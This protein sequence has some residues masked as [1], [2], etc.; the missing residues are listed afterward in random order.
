MARHESLRTRFPAS[1]GAPWQQILPPAS[2]ALPLVDLSALPE[3]HLALL[4]AEEA[5]R[6]FDLA[7]GPL[8]R[9][10]LVRLGPEA[11]RLLVT[12]HHIVSDGWSQEIL[13]R[14]TAAFREG[15]TLPELPVQYADFALWQ[16]GWL[17]GE[18]LASQLDWWRREFTGDVPPLDLPTDHPRPPRR[19]LRG[20]RLS[21]Q[22]PAGTAADLRKLAREAGATPFLALLAAYQT[23]LHRLSGQDEIRVG[24]PV[25]NRRRV[26]FEGLIG[27]FVNTLVLRGSFN[28]QT[29]LSTLLEQ[30]KASALGAYA[31]QDVPFERLVDEL[32]PQRDPS[33]TPLFQAMLAF[34]VGDATQAREIDNGTAKFELTLSLRQGSD[35]LVG[36][37]EYDRDLF[38]A[39][40]AAR[41]AGGFV[42][43]L[44]AG[45]ADP[46][47]LV[48]ELP[49][50]TAAQRRQILTEWNDTRVPLPEDASLHGLFEVQAA[51]TPDAVAVLFGEEEVTYRD[52]DA[53]ASRLAHRLRG[54]GAGPEV[55]VGL[56]AERSLE[57]VA[58]LLGILKSGAFYVPLDP[59]YPRERLA[60]M[61]EDSGA[62]LVLTQSHLLETLPEVG[63]RAVILEP[64]SG[65]NEPGLPVPPDSLAYTI[66][67][68][69]STGRPKGVQVTHGAV[70]NFLRAMATWPG[71]GARDTL[72]SVT[73]LS[74]DIAALEIFLPLATGARVALAG[75]E[76]VADG[77]R[78]AAELERS[79]ATAMQATP[80]T[81]RLLLEAGWEGTPG[82]QALCGGEALPRELAQ[83]LVE[84]AAAVW[85]LYGPTETTIWSAVE[86][87][88]ATD[89]T[90]PIGLPIA[91]TRLH[92]VDRSFAPLPVGV[93]GELVI[94]GAGLARGYR[95][96]PDLTAERFV[97]DPFEE[98][99]VRLYRTGDRARRLADGRIEFLGRLDHQV[100]VR[101][102]RIELGEIEAALEGHP[103][104]A[105][106]V[107]AVRQVSGDPRLI[108]WLVSGG[109][110]PDSAE[111]RGFLGATLP[112][113]MIPSH[114]EI[115][116]SLPL[117]P[118]GKVDRRALPDPSLSGTGE[119][120][121]PS[122][123]IEETVA[124]IWSRVLGIAEAG[125]HQSFFELGGHS[126]L[127]TRVLA[128]INETF[129]ISLPLRTLFETPTVAGLARAVSEARRG[130]R[131][132]PPFERLPRGGP[133]ALS[134]A[135]ERLWVME[136]LTPESPVYNL[137][138]ALRVTGPLHAVLLERC[139]AEVLRRH[140][141]LRTTFTTIQGRPFQIVAAAGVFTLPQVDLR[142]L[143]GL[144]REM[145][146][147][148][149]ARAE[150]RRPFDL[151]RGPLFRASLARLDEQ[152]WLLTIAIHHIVCDDASIGLLVHEVAA[153][154]R[155][156]SMPELSFQY[157]D[158]A[159]W[160]RRWLSGPTLEA[161]IGYWNEKLRGELPVLEL[162]A[163]RPRPPV[164]TF[165]GA[166]V[167][168]AIP[169]P[170]ATA[171]RE[172]SRRQGATPFM[173]LLAAFAAVLHQASG[174]DDLILGT[175]VAGRNRVETEGMIGF[176][177][178][179]LP[180][181]ID[182]SGSPTWEDLLARVRETALEAYDHQDLPF[183][184]L[185]EALQPKRDLGRAAIR[186]A[187][188][189]FQDTAQGA[190]ELPGGVSALPVPVD[191]GVSR[192]DLTLFL[193]P[194][195]QGFSGFCEY[196]TD[197]FDRGTVV[198]LLDGFRQALEDM[199][200]GRP[201]LAPAAE[202]RLET[203][204]TEGQLL[205]WFARKLNPD[206]QLYFER[207]TVT[208][209]LDGAPDLPAFKSAFQ[210]LVDTC[211][212]LRTR[213]IEVQGVPWRSVSEPAPVQIERLDISPADLGGWL[214]RRGAEPMDPAVRLFD[215]A[216]V[217]LGPGR[218]VWFFSAHHL[219]AD[220]WTLQ[221]LARR[222][223]DLY[224]LARRGELAHAPRFRSY[225]E[226]AEAERETRRS[227]RYQKAR[228]YWEEKL[229]RRA[230]AN[231]F[232]R[233]ALS[234]T[235]T[236]RL[237]SEL[238]PEASAA[239]R[240]LTSRLSVFSPSIV[241][242]GALL[243]LLHRLNSERRQ[244]IGTPVANRPDRFRET[245]GLMMNAV[246]LEV[247]IEPAESF[248]TLARKLQRELVE[249]SRHQIHPVRNP[250]E[251]R[252]WD[253]YFNFQ[254]M[255]FREL[256]GLPARFELLHSGHSQDHL[257]LQV[258]DFG[259]SE[260]YRLDF[261]FN[262]ACF[263]EGE[264]QR[265]LGHALALL[266]AFLEDPD[267]ALT[268][269]PLL[270]A[271]ERGQ[272]V[273][274]FNDTAAVYPRGVTLHSLIAAQIER[275]PD[276]IAVSAEEGSL[277]Y[278]ELGER[279]GRLAA[280]LQAQGVG[281]DSR[282]GISLERSL[283]LMVALLGTL[284]AGGAYVP[285][286]PGYPAE[287][288]AWLLEDSRVSALLRTQENLGPAAELRDET[289]EDHLA[290][291]IYT[292]GSTGRPKGV[293][294]SHAG[295]CNR[296]F[297]MQEAFGLTPADRVL[298]KTPISFDVSVWEFFWP[299]MVGARL[300]MARPGGHQDP[301]YLVSTIVREG[302][303]TLHFVPSML[304]VFLEQPGVERCAS[305]V[306]VICSGEALPDPLRR[307]F[308]ER[309]GAELHNLYGPT[310][311]SVDVTAWRSDPAD[312]DPIV[313]IG[314]PIAN[315]RTHVLGPQLEPLP[316]G[317]PGELL[318]GGIG[319]ARG[320][321]GRPDLTAERFVP[322]PF[323]AP[324]DRLYRTGDLARWRPDGNLEYL[325]R[326]DH[327]VKIR[328]F[329]IELG[330]I[331]AALA[332]L[333]GVREA[334][335]T[336]REDRPGDRRLAAYY[337]GGV[338]AD[339]LRESLRAK[340]PEPMVPSAFVALDA[341]PLTPSGKVDR[342]SLPAP[343]ETPR[344][345][346]QTGPRTPLELLIASVCAEVL[347]V[348]SVPVE[349][350]FFD[351][352]GNSL[353][354]TQVVTLLQDALPI[355]LD[356]RQVFE[357]PTV[358]RLATL[359]EAGQ[360]A[361]SERERQAMAMILSE[362][363]EG[364]TAL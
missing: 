58:G 137:F 164:Q 119:R 212:V 170:L 114:F 361:L 181:R 195:E 69:G 219:I 290:Y 242:A 29:D 159:D 306:R 326:T 318:L 66:F 45:L 285:I 183:E 115:L 13:L 339:T 136:R 213:V 54:L 84:R 52:L 292:S 33:R 41:I 283:D 187:G 21:L 232:Y 231:P 225:E 204:L 109:T 324:G 317:I 72:L 235:R 157:A 191:P 350:S 189:A 141:A 353:L 68:S 61:L 298:Q 246:P 259:A 272:L 269:A 207:A 147:A 12:M 32:Q 271:S 8:L 160:Q 53:R 35:G 348:E 133:L 311:A 86:R 334:A 122:G 325:G 128:R 142:D 315:I 64:G 287:R 129:R 82:L 313:P 25:A 300:V 9:A 37:L 134:F 210:T 349:A 130:E 98:D 229:S 99:G 312:R 24:T 288:V 295:I 273:L 139:F 276:A 186:Q 43:L 14:E 120:E 108:A 240:G 327:Q 132:A 194:S 352:G 75:R 244:R 297:W 236:D 176:F 153:L 77:A 299:L 355:E 211:D 107:A 284:R 303:T 154:Y 106:A 278:R 277:T 19:T 116:E 97:P 168:V 224:A 294:V 127:A 121:A 3:R 208:F 255:S 233:R 209:T 322:D 286:D 201:L 172:L 332:G 289:N 161:E 1:E 94:G 175:P 257:G 301:A 4:E 81:W 281:P 118:N 71:L 358:A 38:E 328:G 11:H 125:R 67:T 338:S 95:G 243:A 7:R 83:R 279:S 354:A 196:S 345:E 55:G 188:F 341:M 56:C 222:L 59:S 226:Y 260:S 192:L 282:V 80:A 331:E 62:P 223:S 148:R 309:L 323:G 217:R 220:A 146:A 70:V 174:Q 206:V 182:L 296:L 351:L 57:M 357:A 73:T 314:R 44:E 46:R 275:T 335:V 150:A 321:L 252:A 302:I 50:L 221:I 316:L 360:G 245:P 138:Q 270:S 179:V 76:T 308:H 177:V 166:L 198:R 199:V 249:V 145:E 16:R 227:E 63:A 248:A 205:F 307:R 15:A 2:V 163:D 20:G 261:D 171:V 34:Q 103:A 218:T 340:L 110:P 49:L 228:A 28:E 60:W 23:L 291:V 51:R 344:G 96:R 5:R 280:R 346:D 330:E 274:A 42:T 190:I 237:S 193:W 102:F 247:E 203:N 347:G 104:V 268:D 156:V 305:L 250:I 180:L 26:E 144:A 185:V 262:R 100:K 27:F 234:T 238:S 310:E 267:R 251:D 202:R 258:S 87:V 329:R 356:L 113:F 31:H 200:A 337:V 135:Q 230:A 169:G 93:P 90:V 17:E 88:R 18:T 6:P 117:T 215:T 263:D 162:P 74:F 158:Y 184:K 197:L 359:V 364:L 85:N 241:F 124:A 79:G 216:L 155:H 89:R 336:L 253:V 10:L 65:E 173:A 167:P 178:N 126:L 320:Y 131:L 36:W 22:L 40:T 39:A 112:G 264:R 266:A 143:D 363:E 123:P 239:A 362:F 78:L 101:G 214:D 30:V 293:M 105:R 343:S 151:L 342:R 140:E 91:N 256:C 254:V 149:L 304:Q 48:S 265:T 333:P 111:L 165:R 92:V 47:R 319:L 152:S